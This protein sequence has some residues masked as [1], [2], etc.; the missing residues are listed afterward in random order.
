MADRTSLRRSPLMLLGGPIVAFAVWW[1]SPILFNRNACRS[2]D[3]HERA[4]ALDLYGDKADA[5][6][7]YSEYL[8]G[9]PGDA[10]AV[11]S[12]GMAYMSLGR[13]NDA[14][15]DFSA[16]LR[17]RPGDYGAFRW[18][19]DAYLLNAD[20]SDAVADY[21]RALDRPVGTPSGTYYARGLA[22]LH[23]GQFGPAAG[24]FERALAL[25]PDGPGK[26]YLEKARTCALFHIGDGDCAALPLDTN[27]LAIHLIEVSGRGLSGC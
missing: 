20:Y 24:D 7:A 16:V 6:G 15:A 11:M 4:I 25:V 19:G 26:D 1:I 2:S 17:Q 21:T 9:H 8:R 13:R 22:Y 5:V 23:A 3:P 14:I 27:P 18:R 10:D 12:R